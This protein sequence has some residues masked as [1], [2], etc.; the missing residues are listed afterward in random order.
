M[1]TEILKIKNPYLQGIGDMSM[2]THSGKLSH[3]GF[4]KLIQMYSS[5]NETLNKGPLDL[6][7]VF[8]DLPR[9]AVIA[10]VGGN[11]F[12][13][14]QELAKSVKG[15]AESYLIA[16]LPK[17]YSQGYFNKGFFGFF[18]N[19]FVMKEIVEKP[20]FEFRLEDFET[21]LEQDFSIFNP[22]KP[23][24]FFTFNIFLRGDIFFVELS[25]KDASYKLDENFSDYYKSIIYP[26]HITNSFSLIFCYENTYNFFKNF[27]L[28]YTGD[29][30]VDWGKTKKYLNKGFNEGFIHLNE[31]FAILDHLK[32]FVIGQGVNKTMSRLFESSKVEQDLM[33]RLKC[34][35]LG[36]YG[37]FGFIGA[38]LSSKKEFIERCQEA[39]KPDC[40]LQ[41]VVYSSLF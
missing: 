32:D 3:S 1:L 24:K 41:D 14:N 23:E 8:I 7:T 19:S 2:C 22:E 12:K 11:L 13:I 6:N 18:L 40:S 39:F 21:K 36:L 15:K 20:F 29:K 34:F 33:D 5:V 31:L 9:V 4:S 30:K 37:R 38:N 16:S 35:L 10:P 25:Y 28:Y 27:E 17:I 26:E